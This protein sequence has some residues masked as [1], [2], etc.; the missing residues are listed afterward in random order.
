MGSLNYYKRYLPYL[1]EVIKVFSSC[2]RRPEFEWQTNEQEAFDNSKKLLE[3]SM[4]L[5]LP[6]Q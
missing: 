4:E 3:G 6:D 5:G 2:L 1:S